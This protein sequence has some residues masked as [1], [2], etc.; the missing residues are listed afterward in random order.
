M[1]LSIRQ[2]VQNKD[3]IS[4]TIQQNRSL[5]EIS[6]VWKKNIFTPI[7]LHGVTGQWKN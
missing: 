4:S 3:T 2:S 6:A 7:L 1:P 5:E